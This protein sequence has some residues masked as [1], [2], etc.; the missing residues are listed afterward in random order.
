MAW[1]I[2]VIP[3]A[4]IAFGVEFSGGWMIVRYVLSAIFVAAL[5]A[6]LV[7]VWRERRANGERAAP[8]PRRRFESH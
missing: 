2:A 7:A 3:N 1:G 6:F 8:R 5:I 4:L